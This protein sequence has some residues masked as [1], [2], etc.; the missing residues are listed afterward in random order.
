MQGTVREE[1]ATHGNPAKGPCGKPKLPWGITVMMKCK[2]TTHGN[3]PKGPCGKPKLPWGITVMIKCKYSTTVVCCKLC[4]V[5]KC[6]YVLY[7]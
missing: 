3:R 2:C 5:D 1:C 4:C 7:S 6:P